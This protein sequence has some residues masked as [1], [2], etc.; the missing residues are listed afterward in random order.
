MRGLR[1]ERCP[2]WLA[3][4]CSIRSENTVERLGN[5]CSIRLSYGAVAQEDN[6]VSWATES[7]RLASDAEAKRART[8][9]SHLCGRHNPQLADRGVSGAGDHVGDAVGDI[10][11][12]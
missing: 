1:D 5:R 6:V 2:Q 3:R 8:K 4:L 12:D 10:F 9:R 7:S 11:G